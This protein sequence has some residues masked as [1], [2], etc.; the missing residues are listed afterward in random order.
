MSYLVDESEHFERTF[1]EVCCDWCKSESCLVS[2][3]DDGWMCARCLGIERDS[4]D[5]QLALGFVLEAF[6]PQEAVA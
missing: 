6:G 4:I 2:L 5:V 1:P 3:G